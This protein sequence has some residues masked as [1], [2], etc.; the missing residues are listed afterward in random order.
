ML[1]HCRIPVGSDRVNGQR[2]RPYGRSRCGRIYLQQAH[3]DS[4][5]TAVGHLNAGPY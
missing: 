5:Q 4:I 1:F 3:E 2:E